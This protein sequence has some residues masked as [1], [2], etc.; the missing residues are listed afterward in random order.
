VEVA[1]AAFAGVNKSRRLQ[2]VGVAGSGGGD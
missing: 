1:S 2:G